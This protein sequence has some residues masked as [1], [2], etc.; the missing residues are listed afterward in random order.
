MKFYANMTTLP[1]CCGFKEAGDFTSDPDDCEF[2]SNTVERLVADLLKAA[3]GRPVIFNFV[4]NVDW[5]GKFASHYE[6]SELRTYVRNHPKAKHLARFINPGSK[7][8]I[9]SY[10][11]SDYQNDE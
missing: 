3:K 5:N 11:I 1:Y 6:A 10:M 2:V 7:N 8:R 4:K 9:D